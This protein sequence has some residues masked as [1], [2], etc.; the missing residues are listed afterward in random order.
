MKN[1]NQVLRVGDMLYM[2]IER[3]Q[4]ALNQAYSEEVTHHYELPHR[5]VAIPC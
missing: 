5:A 1:V 4:V 2:E 3:L